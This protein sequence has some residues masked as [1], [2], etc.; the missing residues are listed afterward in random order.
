[1]LSLRQ[2]NFI[3]IVQPARSGNSSPEVT[4]LESRR[5]GIRTQDTRL[6]SP[7]LWLRRS[8]ALAGILWGRS[9]CQSREPSVLCSYRNQGVAWG[10][11]VIGGSQGHICCKHRA[12]TK[13]QRK[14]VGSTSASESSECKGPEA[15]THSSGS[16]SSLGLLH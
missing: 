13:L 8:C 11:Q 2:Y 1:M 3:P 4:P 5:P 16:Q 14:W 7:C 12:F 10:S 9:T 6:Q 15:G